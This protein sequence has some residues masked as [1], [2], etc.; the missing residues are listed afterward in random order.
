VGG[1]CAAQYGLI[2]EGETSFPSRAS[3]ALPPVDGAV[4]EAALITADLALR[5]EAHSGMGEAL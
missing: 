4:R 3:S 1:D 5:D 2:L